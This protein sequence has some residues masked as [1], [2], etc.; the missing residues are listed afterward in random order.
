[1]NIDITNRKELDLD[2]A[3]N[4]IQHL[5]T[6][7]S[8]ILE[9]DIGNGKTSVGKTLADRTG[10]KLF[11]FDCTTKGIGDMQLP[12][13]STIENGVAR[14]VPNEELGLHLDEPIILNF[15]EI[16]KA[17]K[18]LKDSTLAVL[19]ERRLG[20]RQ[21]HTGSLIFG[22]T[23]MA[24]EGIGDLIEAHHGNRVTLVRVKKSTDIQWRSWAML[25][26]ID[27][28]VINFA[29]EFPE[30]FQSF[31]QVAN[32][33]DNPYIFHPQAGRVSFVTPRSLHAASDIVKL[34]SVLSTN[35]VECAL[36]GT[37]GDAAT[38]SMMA[39]IQLAD[40]LPTLESIRTAPST[41]IV[42]TNSSA[43]CMVVY[44]AIQT[45]DRSWADAWLTYF[46][47]L[48]KESQALFAN[49]VLHKDH[50]QRNFFVTKTKFTEWC[51]A[52]NY[53]NL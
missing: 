48:P 28:V 27:P 26:D 53:L 2:E 37:I 44:K 20:R 17:N 38:N 36:A 52:N 14:F 4:L 15:D 34:R 1:V 29:K 39:Y 50:P 41:A 30:V 35:E 31:Q 40:Q 32:Y 47:R 16:G 13:I 9:G 19:L 45:V 23:N 24:E 11:T 49:G 22:T 21:L 10:Y 3:T 6:K 18:S 46:V 51:H 42:P 33:E 43:I 8:V 12:L 7:R 25:N 5:G